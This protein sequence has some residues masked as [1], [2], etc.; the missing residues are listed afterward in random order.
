MWQSAVMILAV[1][2]FPGGGAR[3]LAWGFVAGSAAAALWNLLTANRPS[4]SDSSLADASAAEA[5]GASIG[6][7]VPIVLLADPIPQLY[8]GA[9]L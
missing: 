9:E 1:W 3:T 4:P 7:W 2:F 6:F 8:S 5:V